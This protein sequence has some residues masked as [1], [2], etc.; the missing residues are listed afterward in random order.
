LDRA[1]IKTRNIDIL[2]IRNDKVK[3]KGQGQYWAKS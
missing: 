1:N 2:Y 3:L